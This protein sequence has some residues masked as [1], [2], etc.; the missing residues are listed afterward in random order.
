MC[1][2]I[3]SNISVKIGFG[4]KTNSLIEVIIVRHIKTPKTLNYNLVKKEHLKSKTKN[5]QPR[6]TNT[7]VE[8]TFQESAKKLVKSHEYTV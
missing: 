7:D 6:R 3:I 1:L 8:T 4:I 2:Q 5:C